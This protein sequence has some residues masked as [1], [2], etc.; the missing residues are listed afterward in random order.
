M[1]PVLRFPQLDLAI[2]LPGSG[3][4]LLGNVRPDHLLPPTW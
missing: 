1:E 3:E 4:H 2:N